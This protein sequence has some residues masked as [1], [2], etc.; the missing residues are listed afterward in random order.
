MRL[1]IFPTPKYIRRRKNVIAIVMTIP[2]R[3][4]AKISENVKRRQKKTRM[5][6][7]RIAPKESGSAK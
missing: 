3:L 6:K 7:K 1:R 5:K 4:F 2:R